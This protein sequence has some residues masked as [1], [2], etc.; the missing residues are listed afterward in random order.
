GAGNNTL[1]LRAVT[2]VD[3]TNAD[4]TMGDVVT[5][6][7][8]LNVDASQL[9]TGVSITGSAAVNVLTGGTGADTIDGNGGA[10]VIAAGGGSDSVTYHG[11]EASIDGGLGSDTLV[12]AVDGGTTSVNLA[13][14]PG[15]DQTVGDVVGVSNFENVDASALSTALSV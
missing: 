9:V 2:T 14:A 15:A 3:L 12:M 4:Q 11:T 1:L 13:A 10:D 5:A 7:N 6:A 8:F